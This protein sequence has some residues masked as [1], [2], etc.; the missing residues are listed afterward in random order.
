MEPIATVC[1]DSGLLAVCVFLR[2]FELLSKPDIS[3]PETGS[4][5]P[6]GKN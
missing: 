5:I 3:L 4:G 1:P 2:T 6:D